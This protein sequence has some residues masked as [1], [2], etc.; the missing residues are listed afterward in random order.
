VLDVIEFVDVNRLPDPDTVWSEIVEAS[1]ASW[2]WSSRSVHMFRVEYLVSAGQQYQ[3]LSFVAL[4]NGIPIGLAPVIVHSAQT[5]TRS[6][7]DACYP[8]APLPW[9]SLRAG[10]EADVEK[11][12]LDEI[13]RRVVEAGAE[14][15]GLMLEAPGDAADL[16]LHFERMVR[17]RGFVDSSFESH[18]VSVAP[19]FLSSIR[20]KYRQNIRKHRGSYDIMVLSGADISPDIVERYMHLHVKDSGGQHRGPS[21]YNKQF[22]ILRLGEGFCVAASRKGADRIVG[23]LMIWFMKGAAYDA[24][25]AVDPEFQHE[26]VSNLLKLEAIEEMA[27]RGVGTY[28][29]GRAL[30]APEY[31]SQPTEKNYGISFFKDGWSRGARRIVHVA[32]KYYDR[33]RL[34]ADW[35]EKLESLTEYFRLQK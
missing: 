1:P 11:R 21:T 18:L 24:S 15:I 13:E 32:E 27:R 3:D 25:V 10:Q 5:D 16:S 35:Q 2:I 14:K 6:R 7:R 20:P 8:G 4:E 29:L 33:R 19:D 26:S 28:E 12:I 17:E 31:L 22:D 34:S 9:P 23:M 30:S